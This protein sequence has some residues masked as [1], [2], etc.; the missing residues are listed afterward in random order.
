[1]VLFSDLTDNFG[2]N[3][4][5]NDEFVTL[6]LTHSDTVLDD[7]IQEDQ[8]SLVT[9]DKYPFAIAVFT[10]HTYTV[11]VRVGSHNDVCI[12][13]LSQLDSQSKSLSVFRVRRNYCWEVTALNH[14]FGHAMYVFESPQLKR[15]R[16]KHHTCTVD[17]SINYLQVFLTFD[18]FR[19]DRDSVNTTQVFIVYFLTDNLNQVFVAFEFNL[20]NRNFIYFVNDTLIV[21]SKNLSAIIPVSLVTVVFFRVVRSSQDDTA[22]ASQ[23]A[24][25]ERHFRSRTHIIEQVYLDTVSREDVSRDFSEFSTVVTAVVTYY[26]RDIFLSFETFVQVV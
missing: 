25:S 23:L 16:D 12:Y 9:V 14:L 19:I 20:V 24:D 1:M 18:N 8:T 21:R 26:N 2:S 13:F 7:V 22:L 10:S 11:S 3:D 4:S 17:R 15:L 6:H 5:L